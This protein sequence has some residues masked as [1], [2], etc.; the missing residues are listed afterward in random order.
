MLG[1]GRLQMFLLLLPD[2]FKLLSMP[3]FQ[4]CRGIGHNIYLLE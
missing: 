3:F 4:C 1:G 2:A